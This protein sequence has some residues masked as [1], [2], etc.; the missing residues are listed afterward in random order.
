MGQQRIV[1]A[2]EKMARLKKNAVRR[3]LLQGAAGPNKAGNRNREN[4]KP[5]MEQ[6]HP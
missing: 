4:R 3:R 1:H 5:L 6:I 2:E